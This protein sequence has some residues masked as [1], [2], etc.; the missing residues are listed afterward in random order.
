MVPVL[1]ESLSIT[2][3]DD[4]VSK[5]VEFVLRNLIQHTLTLQNTPR[6]KKKI[7][8]QFFHILLIYSFQREMINALYI[9]SNK[10]RMFIL[11][12]V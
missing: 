5:S 3:F 8:R 6:E 2:H 11:F 7:S 12:R 4:I 1:D 9:E 10:R